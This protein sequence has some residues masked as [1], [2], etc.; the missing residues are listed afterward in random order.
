MDNRFYAQTYEGVQ[1]FMYRVFGWMS[2][3]LAL[4]GFTAYYVFTSEALRKMIFG[5]GFV[6]ILLILAQLGLVIALSTLIQRIRY[7]TAFV[8]FSIYSVLTGTTL[9]TIF[10]MYTLPSIATT[11]FVC[12]GMFAFMA[13]YGAYTKADLTRMGTFLY[14]ALIGVILAM[15]VNLFVRSS[16]FDLVLAVI[17]VIIFTGLTAFDVQKIKE[18]AQRIDVD[19]EMGGN[20]SLLAALTLYLDFVNLFLNLLRLFGERKDR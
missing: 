6:V 16:M 5:N 15:V 19:S 4:T 12:A 17:G 8:L 2:Y 13:I 11:F 9:S 3:A 10:L 18:L 1:S 7:T 20:I 14:M